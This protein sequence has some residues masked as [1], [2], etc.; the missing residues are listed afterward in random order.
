MSRKNF[1]LSYV[2]HEESI[3]TS[4]PDFGL[5][6]LLRTIAII[7]EREREREE[8]EREREKE[9]E[10]ERDRQTERQRERQRERERMS[11]L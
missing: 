10:R 3:I 7:R 6:N 4:G 8:R 11:I 5:H 1:T 2:E 9:R